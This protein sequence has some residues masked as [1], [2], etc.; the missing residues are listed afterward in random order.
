MCAIAVNTK[1]LV[2]REAYP[3]MKSLVPQ[4]KTAAKLKAVGEVSKGSII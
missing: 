2:R 3:P 4:E 1:A